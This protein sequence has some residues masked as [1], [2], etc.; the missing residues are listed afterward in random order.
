MQQILA[1]TDY[2]FPCKLSDMVPL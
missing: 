2:L 1:H